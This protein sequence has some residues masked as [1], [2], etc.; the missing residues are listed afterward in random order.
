MNVN[1]GFTKKKKQNMMALVPGR[2]TTI[3]YKTESFSVQNYHYYF[4]E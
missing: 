1:D 2:R 4:Y 3:V